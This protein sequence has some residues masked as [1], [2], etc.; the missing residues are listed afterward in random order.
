MSISKRIVLVV[1]LTLLG[2][3]AL[4]ELGRAEAAELDQEDFVPLATQGFLTAVDGTHPEGSRR[5]S[6]MWSMRWWQEKLYVGTLRDAF[7]LFGQ[8]GGGQA[9]R[10]LPPEGQ[11]VRPYL[12][13]PRTSGPRSG[14]TPLG[15]RMALRVLG[16]ECSS[17]R[18]CSTV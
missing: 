17:P 15:G 5:N 18:C 8:A 16:K 11:Y 12:R 4:S 1:G 6:Y 13:S 3:L 9:D 10:L 7:C 14:N 2:L